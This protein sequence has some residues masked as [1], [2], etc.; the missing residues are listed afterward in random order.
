MV[1]QKIFIKKLILLIFYYKVITVN[2][3][4]NLS[5]RF[6]V[7]NNTLLYIEVN[8]CFDNLQTGNLYF[9]YI[10]YSKSLL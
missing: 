8:E 10:F 3:L 6:L 4:D 9:L 1:V 2:A 7:T 5:D